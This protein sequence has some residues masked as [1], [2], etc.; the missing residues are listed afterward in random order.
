MEKIYKILIVDDDVDMIELLKYNLEREG[1]DVKAV[2][3]SQLAVDVAIDFM[4]DLIVLATM[5]PQKSGIEICKKL[6]LLPLFSATYIFFLT[7]TLDQYYHDQDIVFEAGGDDFI[8]KRV[9]L[10]VL[11]NKIL[12]VLKENFVIRKGVSPLTFGDLV[13]NRKSS[14][15]YLK[16][17]PIS[18][19]RQEFDLLFFFAQNPKKV[20]TVDNLV[21]NI[22]GSDTFLVDL[23]VASYIKSIS[24]KLK[25]GWIS[26]VG[27]DEYRFNPH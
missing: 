23:P 14:A 3:D 22:W 15:V 17:Q 26:S 12:T 13:I 10:R 19:S 9:G 6:R 7:S 27:L 1:F 20:I 24:Q 2:T 16:N 21:S 18:F 8:E 11:T 25:D 5:V 4:P